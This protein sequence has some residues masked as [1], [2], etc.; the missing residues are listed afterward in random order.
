MKKLE[1]FLEKYG[2]DPL[3]LVEE[4]H[5]ANNINYSDLEGLLSHFHSELLTEFDTEQLCIDIIEVFQ[6]AGRPFPKGLK[7]DIPLYKLNPTPINPKLPK[8]DKRDILYD[9][10]NFIGND[11][12]RPALKGVYVDPDGYLVATDAMVQLSYQ[13]RIIDEYGGKILNLKEYIKTGKID[14]LDG[15]YPNWRAIIDQE[16]EFR[17]QDVNMYALYNL[18]SSYVAISKYLYKNHNAEY[19]I[20]DFGDAQKA[21]TPAFIEDVA[22]FALAYGLS[23]AEVVFREGQFRALQFNFSDGSH[24]IIMP[25]QFIYDGYEEKNDFYKILT[26]YD[27]GV[28]LKAAKIRPSKKALQPE[29]SAEMLLLEQMI[30]QN[31]S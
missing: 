29:K 14:F 1:L 17:I 23:A 8:K 24:A 5:T 28:T 12:S 30:M 20:L 22:R 31:L 6:E 16:P 21:F 10:K 25:R 18:A 19:I 9:L 4:P 13:S 11:D 2:K 3:C 7:A 26:R 27:G 15:T